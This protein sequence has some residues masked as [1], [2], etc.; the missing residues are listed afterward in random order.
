MSL[1]C[2][3]V[4]P[5]YNESEVLRVTL[6]RIIECVNLEFEC[7]IVVDEVSDTSIPIILEFQNTDPRFKILINENLT[8]I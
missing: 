8:F 4:I 3:L 1:R 5:A 2:S 7:I 6:T